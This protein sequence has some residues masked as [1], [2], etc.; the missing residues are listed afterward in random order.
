[1]LH[2]NNFSSQQP[3]S[4]HTQTH[5]LEPKLKVI[6]SKKQEDNKSITSVFLSPRIR[7]W[8]RQKT[9]NNFRDFSV[10]TRYSKTTN[11]LMY[12]PLNQHAMTNTNPADR[13]ETH[14]SHHW[15]NPKSSLICFSMTQLFIE[16][17][18][19]FM[20]CTG[21]WPYSGKNCFEHSLS[22]ACHPI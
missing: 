17:A 6:R 11:M 3:S 13:Q 8:P 12:L 10:T 1:M 15:H 22:T 4:I 20:K 16:T 7:V 19:P 14:H 2:Y 5:P 18:I 9:P 21:S